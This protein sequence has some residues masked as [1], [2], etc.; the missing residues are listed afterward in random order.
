MTIYIPIEWLFNDEFWAMW[1]TWGCVSMTL[2]YLS[3]AFY[4]T[5][6]NDSHITR[7]KRP[8]HIPSSSLISPTRTIL[9]V[10]GGPVTAIL[11]VF[12]AWGALNAEKM[13]RKREKAAQDHL[14][15]LVEGTTKRY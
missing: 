8:H 3:G 5:K 13:Y 1:L 10:M 15:R 7:G 11:P 6:V 4:I 9:M 2:A 12:G 14:N